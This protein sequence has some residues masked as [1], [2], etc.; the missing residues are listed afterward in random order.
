ML[1]VILELTCFASAPT[2]CGIKDTVSIVKL[3]LI[4]QHYICDNKQGGTKEVHF[5][6]FYMQHINACPKH[7][8]QVFQEILYK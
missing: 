3:S 5:M 1:T 4:T 8:S 2:I 7:S 6:Y